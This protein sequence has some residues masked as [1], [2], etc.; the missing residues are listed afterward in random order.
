MCGTS[1]VQRNAQRD[2][3]RLGALVQL[4]SFFQHE[5]GV[6]DAELA[7]RLAGSASLRTLKKGERLVRAGEAQTSVDFL[8]SG[9]LRGF[10]VDVDG[11]ETTGCFFAR[12]GLPAMPSARLDVASPLTL[13]ALTSTTVASIDLEAAQELLSTSIAANQLYIRLLGIGW[14]LNWEVKEVLT[15]KK[16]RERY[17]WFLETY[18]GLIDKV[19]NK[20]VASFLGMTPVTLSR[21]RGILRDEGKA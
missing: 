1:D 18:D 3:Q 4:L 17:L 21:L 13:E 2:G 5:V 20:H 16:A 19:P 10:A 11:H 15:Q 7:E 6:E 12:P 14:Q 8:C 9:V